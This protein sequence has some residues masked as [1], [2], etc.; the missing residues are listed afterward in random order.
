MKELLVPVGNMNSLM[1]AINAGADAVYLAGKKYGARASAVN[2]DDEEMVRAIKLCHLY[3][4]KIYVTVNTLIYESEFDHVLE[5]VFFLYK[6]GVDAIIVQDIGLISYL[7]RVLPDLEIHASTQ[8]HNT[9]DKTLKFL[10]SLGV[11]RVVLARELSVDEINKLETDIELEAFIHGAICVSYSG[12]CLFSSR[13]L[14]RSGNR[15][16]CA[17]MCRLPYELYLG[18][19]LVETDGNFLL[20]PKELNTSSNFV[21]IME[22]NIYSLKIEGRLKSPEYVGCVTKLYRSLI[23]EYE[24]SGKC[25][26]DPELLHDIKTIFNR[27]FTEGFIL[28]SS[29]I[30]L[31]NIKTSNHQGSYLGKVVDIYKK[32]IKVKLSDDLNQGDGIRFKGANEGMIANFIYDTKENLINSAKSGEC[33]LLDKRFGIERGDEIAKTFSVKIRDKYTNLSEKKIP[34]DM[35]FAAHQGGALTLSISDGEHE[36]T[37]NYGTVEASINHPIDAARIKM[38]LCK[39]GNTPFILNNIDIVVD[40]SSF[41]NI[42]DINEVRRLATDELINL[43]EN[44]NRKEDLNI[45]KKSTEYNKTYNENVCISVLVRNEEQLKYLLDKVDRIY[46]PNKALYNKYKDYS[47]VVYRTNRVSDTFE[48]KSL[49]TELG[50][51]ECGGVGDYFLNVTNHESINI[52]SE[53][54]DIITLSCELEDEEIENIMNYYKNKVNVEILIYSRIELMLM[55]YCPLKYLVNKG[56]NPCNVCSIGQSCLVIGQ[57][58]PTDGKKKFPLV[59]DVENH[60]AHILNHE[61]TEKI[62]KVSFYKSIGIRN[63]RI[64][65]FDESISEID[66]IIGDVKEK[67]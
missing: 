41:I 17:Q 56:K 58:C 14:N 47:N 18:D 44:K 34:V 38:Q 1:V 35:K 52:L 32:Y 22:S 28:N 6:N 48:S 24:A 16:E 5:Y 39:L 51:L 23:D 13:L 37:K 40:K 42:K 30:H 7:R 29:L 43:R 64:E 66:K 20:S 46:V 57:K 53:Y 60:T 4:V 19:E 25:H 21:K 27:D 36:V 3:G 45:S 54:L 63:F 62:D 26:I 10:K 55:K 49:V 11:K 59:T 65:L 33:V 31:M 2:F 50:S 12:E 9:N 15:G 67:L 8:V 61:V